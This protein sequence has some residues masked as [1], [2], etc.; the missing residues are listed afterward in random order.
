MECIQRS[1]A[2]Q[3]IMKI[4]RISNPFPAKEKIKG[5]LGPNYYYLSKFTA[6]MGFDVH[7][8]TGRENGQ[9][10][11]EEI[12]GIKIHRVAP[13]INRRSYLFGEFAR[14]CFEKVN[15]I[16]PDL[17]HGH[18]VYISDVYGIKQKLRRRLSLISTQCL[19]HTSIWTIYHSHLI[20]NR[21]S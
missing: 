21:C 12:D 18:T 3:E 5:D 4:C 2:G 1:Y 10:P 17:I 9:S 15:E 7:V 11:Y 6:D 19:M 14:K 13:L 16:K 8:I 20:Q